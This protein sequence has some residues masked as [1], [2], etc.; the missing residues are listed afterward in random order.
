MSCS[1]GKAAPSDHTKLRLFADSGGFCQNPACLR[2]LFVDAGGDNLHVAEMAHIFAASDEGPRANPSMTERERGVYENLILLCPTC[3]TIIDKAPSAYPDKTIQEWKTKH[4]ARIAAEFGAVEY[5]DRQSIRNSISP[6]LNQNRMIFETCGP[7]Q[8]YQFNPESDIAD[9]WRR[10]VRSQILPN[11]RK[12]LAILD[13][14][15]RHLT[16]DEQTILEQFRQHVDD[17]ETRHLGSGTIASGARFPEGMNTI[18][19]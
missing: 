2:A 13:A 3:H 8:D 16:A 1:R 19:L 6:I 17:L 4:K 15:R 12:L 10:K 18:L 9:V 14:N 11:N 7:M 5:K